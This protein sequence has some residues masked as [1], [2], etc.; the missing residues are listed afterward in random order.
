MNDNEANERKMVAPPAF[1]TTN[2]NG[3]P[4]GIAIIATHYRME[5]TG[6]EP[7]TPCLQSRCSPN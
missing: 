1:P 7:V 6:L 3:G 2:A 5:R 4:F